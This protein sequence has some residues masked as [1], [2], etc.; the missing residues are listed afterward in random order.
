RS[1]LVRRRPFVLRA[2]S[3]DLA[4][5][6]QASGVAALTLVAWVVCAAGAALSVGV[7]AAEPQLGSVPPPSLALVTLPYAVLA[8]L[9]WWGRRTSTARWVAVAGAVLV[10]GLGAALWLAWAD[11]PLAR[12]AAPRL[13]PGRQLV[14]VAVVA[15][16]VYL[17][18]RSGR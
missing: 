14:A 16:V 18:R 7:V 10:L 8:A 17:A 4:P 15:Y 13:I 11:A 5:E 9:A 6:A 12:L 3:D 1:C 2:P